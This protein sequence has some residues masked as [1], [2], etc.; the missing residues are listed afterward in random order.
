MGDESAALSDSGSSAFGVRRAR[1]GWRHGPRERRRPRSR[2]SGR[3]RPARRGW[4]HGPGERRRPRS[5]GSGRAHDRARRGWR[6]G[7]GER[8]RRRSRGSGRAHDRAQGSHSS[9]GGDRQPSVQ[10][11]RPKP[12]RYRAHQEPAHQAQPRAVAR[13]FQ[14]VDEALHLRAVA[15][16]EPSRVQRED[17]SQ[18]PVAHVPPIAIRSRP[19]AAIRA[20]SDRCSCRRLRPSAVIVYG[21]RRSTAGCALTKP[22]RSS[23]ASAPYRVPGPS[24]TPEN[25][26]M[27]LINAYPC[28]SPPARLVN[29]STLRSGSRDLR[30]GISCAPPR[31][32]SSHVAR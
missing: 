18:K 16:S 24:V 7:P 25:T 19:N 6:H 14:V 31:R 20:D 2:G 30:P 17:G 9:E 22:S 8:R 32:K 5:R 29:T 10:P 26:A 4:R 15:P 11:H 1:R 28:L 12:L 3:A 13:S 23:R 21:R 27:S